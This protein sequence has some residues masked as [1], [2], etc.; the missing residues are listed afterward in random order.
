MSHNI[1]LPEE[2]YARAAEL[3]QVDHVSIEEFVSS[4]LA[5]QLAGRQY[6]DRRAQRASRELFLRALE[7]V[8]D[9]EPES[10][11]RF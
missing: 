11:D 10:Y 2:L 3:A 1:L 7:Q 8:P 5:D 9:V 4:A 6:L